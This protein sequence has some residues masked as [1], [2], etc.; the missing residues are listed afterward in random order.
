MLIDSK[1]EISFLLEECAKWSNGRKTR[2]LNRFQIA[3]ELIK[4]LDK[5]LS[6]F[7]SNFNYFKSLILAK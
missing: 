1:Y 6:D 4:S 7:E 2:Y 5:I 3:N